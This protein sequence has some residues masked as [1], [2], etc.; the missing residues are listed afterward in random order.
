MV[1]YGLGRVTKE[2]QTWKGASYQDWGADL[3]GEGE[4]QPTGQQRSLLV[5]PGWDWLLA[6]RKQVSGTQASCRGACGGNWRQ[7][8]QEAFRTLISTLRGSQENYC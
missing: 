7:C 4:V 8:R 3:I 6:S 5:Y 2:G 1:S